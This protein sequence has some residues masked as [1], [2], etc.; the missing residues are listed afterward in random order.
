MHSKLSAS[1]SET[2]LSNADSIRIPIAVLS[3]VICIAIG[4]T[5]FLYSFLA[6]ASVILVDLLG[7]VLT[8]ASSAI[9][10]V[11]EEPYEIAYPRTLAKI[12]ANVGMALSVAAFIAGCRC[13]YLRQISRLDFV[14]CAALCLFMAVLHFMKSMPYA[15]ML[16]VGAIFFFSSMPLLDW[17][18]ANAFG[19]GKQ[20]ISPIGR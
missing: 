17:R 14:V 7:L 12:I 8:G 13:F 16:Y 4:L 3:G 18:M 11:P 5:Q 2:T 20:D 9:A 15:G 1:Q 19:A 10:V 6:F